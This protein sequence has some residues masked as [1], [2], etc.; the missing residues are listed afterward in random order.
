[1]M[2]VAAQYWGAWGRSE[3]P[4]EAQMLIEFLANSTTAGELLGVTRSVPVNA[5]IRDAIANDVQASDKTV[6]TF[7]NDINDEVVPGRLAPP[8]TATFTKSFQRYTSEVLFKR[9]SPMEA[10]EALIKETNDEL[11]NAG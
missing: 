2:F 8:G 6:L 4:A 3:H 9:M 1:M 7:M 5:E 11:A 10:A